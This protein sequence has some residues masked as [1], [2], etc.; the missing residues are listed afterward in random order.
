MLAGS[1]PFQRLKLIARRHPEIRESGCLVEIQ[2]LPARN[3]LKIARQAARPNA[4]I[5]EFGISASKRLNH[6]KRV[7][8]LDG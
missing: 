5:D 1:L 3:L 4:L 7:Y 2:Q 8:P 6:L